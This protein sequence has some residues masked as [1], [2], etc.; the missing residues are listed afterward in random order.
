MKHMLNLFEIG[1]FDCRPTDTLIA[2]NYGLGEFLN[3]LPTSK[4]RYEH[5]VGKLTYL[6]HTRMNIT[7]AVSF[8]SQFMHYPSKYHMSVAICI[9]CHLKFSL[10][11]GLMFMKNQHLH[12]N[13]HTNSDWAWN[14]TDR[15]STSCYLIFV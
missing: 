11:K 13:G 12:I 8:V 1:K 9:L 10:G 7:Y 6:S 5:L 4:D 2:Q 3:Q 14:I 15:K